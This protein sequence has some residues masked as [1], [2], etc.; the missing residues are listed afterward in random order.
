MYLEPAYYEDVVV[1]VKYNEKYQYYVTDKEL[2]I[3]DLNKL[4]AAFEIRG[5]KTELP[6]DERT[7][8][9]V[10]TREGYSI[11]KD[12]IIKYQVSCGELKEYYELFRLTKQQHDDIREILP[13]FYIDFDKNIFYSFYTEPGSYEDYIPS[14]WKG[15]LTDE[16]EKIIPINM[17]YWRA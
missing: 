12:K 17:A 1:L 8:F 5:Y 7:G 11:Y 15:I 2:W 10:L 3:L 6:E 9:A 4:T 13:V 16:F 14:G